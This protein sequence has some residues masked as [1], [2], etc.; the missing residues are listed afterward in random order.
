MCT[1][2][3][4][5]CTAVPRELPLAGPALTLLAALRPH[6]GR[7][8]VVPFDTRGLTDEQCVLR[9]E[10]FS[11]AVGGAPLPP[12]QLKKI[13]RHTECLVF[14]ESRGHLVSLNNIR[15]GV[16]LLC[17]GHAAADLR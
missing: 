15:V 8:A 9:A 14:D 11:L 2:F 3:A 7:V 17:D 6:L 4:L 12:A 5:T 13:A 16:L 1:V 10:G